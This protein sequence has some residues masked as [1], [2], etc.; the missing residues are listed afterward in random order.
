MRP[1]PASRMPGSKALVSSTGPVTLVANM[2][3]HNE[4]SA[5][6]TIPAPEMPALWTRA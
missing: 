1:S 6:S 2:F 4:I 3:C 5:S